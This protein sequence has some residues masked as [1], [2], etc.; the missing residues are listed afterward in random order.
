MLM[1]ELMMIS[2]AVISAFL[3]RMSDPEPIL[4][5]Y[6]I[7]FYLHATLG[8]PIWACQFVAVSFIKDRASMKRLL[9]SASRW[10]PRSP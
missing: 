8:S 1:A 4:A 10:R 5:A 9:S 7:S 2:H 6:S 3:A